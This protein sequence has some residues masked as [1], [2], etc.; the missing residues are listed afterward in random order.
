MR[1]E[2]ADK[3]VAC[4]ELLKQGY[5]QREIAQKL[6]VTLLTT[7]RWC[8][9]IAKEIEDKHKK[10]E[11]AEIEIK[12]KVIYEKERAKEV[13]KE[14]KELEKV[15]T[16]GEL[17]TLAQVSFASCL[18]E[19]KKRLPVMSNEEVINITTALWDRISRN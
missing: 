6:G 14:T 10:I 15:V 12:K 3:L 5:T 17:Q 8:K 11:Q 1:H 4:R 7:N 13:K 2:N 18:T 19:L 9:K 16:A